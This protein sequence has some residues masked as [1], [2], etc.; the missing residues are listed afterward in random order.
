MIDLVLTAH[1]TET[2]RSLGHKH[3]EIN[4]CLNLLERDGLTEA[5]SYKIKRR[6]MQLIAL[7]LS[8]LMKSEPNAQPLLMKPKGVP[9][10]RENS[11]WKAVPG[12]AVSLTSI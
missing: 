12:F 8:I 7:A 4:K 9:A 2:R 6:L 5:E 1:P 3:V 11:L 10:D